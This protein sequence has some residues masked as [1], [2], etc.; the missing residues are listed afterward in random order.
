M[1]RKDI[2]TVCIYKMPRVCRVCSET[3]DDN[4]F[5]PSVKSRCKS[6]HCMR[7]LTTLVPRQAVGKERLLKAIQERGE[8]ID[9][10]RVVTEDVRAMFHWDNRNPADKTRNVTQ[11]LGSSDE[12]FYNEISKCDLVCVICHA[13]RTA[14]QHREGTIKLGRP[15]KYEK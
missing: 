10:K 7:T 14:N 15:R 5:Y 9:C 4:D 13:Q 6:C 8:C 11:M 12:T 3:K 2:E 1:D